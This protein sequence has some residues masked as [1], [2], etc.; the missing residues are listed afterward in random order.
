MADKGGCVI[1]LNGFPGVGKF[2]IA[3]A[4][5][6]ALPSG[7]SHRLIDNHLLIDPVEAIEP[8][9]NDAH[10]RLRKDVRRI[11]FRG[12]E[13]IQEKNVVVIMTTCLAAIPTDVEAF[14]EHAN[15]AL[16]RRVPLITVNISCDESANIARLC[17]DERKKGAVTGKTKLTDAKVLSQLRQDFTLLD[18]D[19]L[20]GEMDKKGLEMH[21]F[22]LETTGL[23]V[24]DATERVLNFMMGRIL[25]L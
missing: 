11:A 22:A 12:V 8:G 21:H 3:K 18:P 7:I 17:G 15:I 19:L 14:H 25:S 16:T 10:Y 13:C 2:T 6:K 20:H 9:R 4:L 24:E 23:T 5:Q 1:L